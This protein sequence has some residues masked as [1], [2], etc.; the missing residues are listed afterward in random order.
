[1]KKFLVKKN[2]KIIQEEG[3]P[4]IAQSFTEKNPLVAVVIGLVLLALG[5]MYLYN[6]P[7]KKLTPVIDENYTMQMENKNDPAVLPSAALS[8]APVKEIMQVNPALDQAHAAYIQEQQKELQQRLAAP[9]M[10]VN[11]SSTIS[12]TVDRSASIE[13]PTDANTQFMHAITSQSTNTVVASTIGPLNWIIAE[14]SFIHAILE[15]ATNSDLPG[16]LRAI[17]TAPNYSEDASQILIPPGSLLI[18]QYKSGML[19]GQSRIFIVWTRLITP[20]GLTL[21]IASPG[22]DGL[23]MAGVAADEIDRHFWARFGTA[24]LL[25]MLGMGSATVAVSSADQAN[26]VSAYRSAMANSFAQSAN[27]SLQQESMIPPTLLSW[28]GK[29]VMVFVAHDL[30]FQAAKKQTK[31]GINIF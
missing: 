19:Q 17:V 4:E 9:I 3:L 10:V 27:Q 20:D 23:G 12:K 31:T 6:K 29:P 7:H 24:S 28:Q 5:L 16:M 30:N 21:Q 26:S 18:G 1:M 14:G 15:P 13:Q 2:K 25:S 11:N 22:V 8:I